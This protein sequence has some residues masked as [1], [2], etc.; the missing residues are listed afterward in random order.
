MLGPLARVRLMHTARLEIKLFIRD[1]SAIRT[2]EFVPIFH[3][4]IQ[5]QADGDLLIDVADYRHLHHG[6]GVVLVA[7][8]AHWATDSAEGRLG[9]S[10]A[11]KRDAEKGFEPRLVSSLRALLGACRR[12]EEE[13]EFVG[14]LVFSTDEI[15]LTIADRLV[16]P[17]GPDLKASPSIDALRSAAEGVLRRLYAGEPVAIEWEWRASA[18]ECLTAILRA[19]R[20]PRVEALLGRLASST[21]DGL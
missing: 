12:I 18:K 20:S 9:L 16:A 1:P 5:G 15:R 4:W 7:Y 3:R 14:R 21:K 10:Y 13:P 8:G 2:E 19:R 6:P 11:R 17:N